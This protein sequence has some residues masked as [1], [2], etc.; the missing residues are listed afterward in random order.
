MNFSPPF[1][2]SLPE[3][4]RRYQALP[5]QERKKTKPM[6]LTVAPARALAGSGGAADAIRLL[7]VSAV[8]SAERL[9]QL[10]RA[11]L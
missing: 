4:P 11:T 8:G 9:G 2:G 6:L 1:D 10:A 7:N 5:A 3:L